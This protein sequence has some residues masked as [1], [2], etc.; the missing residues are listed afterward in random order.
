MLF[1]EAIY[2]LTIVTSL[3]RLFNNR[4]VNGALNLKKKKTYKR[5]NKNNKLLFESI[6]EERGCG[7]IVWREKAHTTHRIHQLCF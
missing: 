6:T 1:I 2:G 5:T 3:E 4:T 7:V